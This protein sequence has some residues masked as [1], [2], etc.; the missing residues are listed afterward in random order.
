MSVQYS[1]RLRVIFREGEWL[2]ALSEKDFGVARLCCET[3]RF[4]EVLREV[5]DKANVKVRDENLGLVLSY[6][7]LIGTGNIRFW[8][9]GGGARRGA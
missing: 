8:V 5:M 1:G 7:L 6:E 4:A 2:F 3:L 9:E